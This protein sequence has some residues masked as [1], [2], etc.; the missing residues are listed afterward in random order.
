MHRLKASAGCLLDLAWAG[1]AFFC[2]EIFRSQ[3]T[4]RD[5]AGH[6]Q[7]FQLH[8]RFHL[9][10]N[11]TRKESRLL[12][13]SR[14]HRIHKQHSHSL[15]RSHHRLAMRSCSQM[16]KHLASFKH[17]QMYMR[18]KHVLKCTSAEIDICMCVCM[19]AHKCACAC[20]LTSSKQRC[21]PACFGE[22]VLV[23]ARVGK[24]VPGPRGASVKACCEHYVWLTTGLL[25]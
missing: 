4:G 23:L 21:A 6:Q 15:C 13:C 7:Y 9:S 16:D 12:S 14:H 19:R 11:Q 3:R 10:L 22:R 24:R 20:A 17:A 8:F 18:C 25:L 1:C 2:R 5:L